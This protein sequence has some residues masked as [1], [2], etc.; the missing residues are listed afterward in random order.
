M[1][2]LIKLLQR[3]FKVR[4]IKN[5]PHGFEFLQDVKRSLP[6][7]R[8]LTIFDVGANVGQTTKIFIDGYPEAKIHCFE[9]V[10]ATYTGLRSEY[11]GNSRVFCW[12]LAM[13]AIQAIVPISIQKDSSLSRVALLSSNKT[14][15]NEHVIDKCIEKVRLFA[16]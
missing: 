16:F 6:A 2:T 14:T 13:G 1:K 3:I 10:S 15:S 5:C 12:N 11:G 9:P 7:F 4:I 8:A